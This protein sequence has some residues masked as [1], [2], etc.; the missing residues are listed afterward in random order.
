M[1][2]VKVTSDSN[3]TPDEC[4]NRVTKLLD[5]DSE[6]R[7]LDPKYVCEFDQT[8]RTGTASGKQ[9]KAKMKVKP[10]GAGSAVEIEVELPFHL[11]LAKGIVQRTLE[12]KL[13]TA[14]S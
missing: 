5:Q 4:F 2:T 12:K 8:G 1:P 9:F 11:A 7:K 3:L 14:L 13:S 6:L 10:N